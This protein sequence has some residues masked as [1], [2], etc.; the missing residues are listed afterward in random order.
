MSASDALDV[1]YD[2]VR[3]VFAGYGKMWIDGPTGKMGWKHAIARTESPDF[4]R[5]SGPQLVI[6][7]DDQD[8]P[9]VEFHTAPVFWHAGR[10]F[11][12]IQVLN[13]TQ[14]GGVMDIELGI[15]RDGLQW[16]RPFRR[17]FVLPRRSGREFDSGSILTCATP[18]VLENEIRFYYGG[19]SGG[20][21]G[22]DDYS[23]TTGI[24][25]ATIPRDRFAGIEPVERSA[26][27]TLRQPVEHRGQIT[28]KPLDLHRVQHLTVNTDA[29]HGSVRGELLAANGRRLR[30]FSE[31]DAVPVRGNHLRQELRWTQSTLADLP[32]EPVLL[33]L[34][35]DRAV[36]FALT[37]EYY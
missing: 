5:W 33:R 13:R 31:E 23:L 6:A 1:F 16:D 12:L 7:P 17:S 11:A 32:A 30:G 8:A 19:Y 20:A 15:S 28:F 27:P 34:H 29:Q 3:Q 4:V 25:F 24:G 35:L 10:Y 14:G 37:L 21:T 18:V 26:Q 2:P 9:E 22:D 36:V